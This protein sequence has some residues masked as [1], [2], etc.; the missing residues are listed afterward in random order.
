MTEIITRER[1]IKA[2]DREPVDDDLERCNCPHA[3]EDGHHHCG[4]NHSENLP[5]FMTL[6]LFITHPGKET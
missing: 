4:W 6:P 5:R 2:V 3:G 1:F